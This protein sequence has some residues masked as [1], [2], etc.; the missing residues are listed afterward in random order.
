MGRNA[1]GALPQLRL[2]KRSGT[3][4]VRVGHQEYWL[5]RWGDPETHRKYAAFVVDYLQRPE[6]AP[7]GGTLS[8]PEVISSADCE[9]RSD[10]EAQPGHI[11]ADATT[12]PDGLT[13]AELCARYLDYAERHYTLPSG[14]KSTTFGNVKMGIRALAPFDRVPAEQ[15]GPVL[16]TKLMYGMVDQPSRRKAKDGKPLPNTLSSINATIKQVRRIF[17][18]A[19]SMEMIPAT[20]WHALNSVELL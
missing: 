17:R 2:H 20:V 1:R 14:Q 7:G 15:F 12:V 18:W 5:G 8:T 6:Q 11:L 13:V 10:A 16:L 4:R 9:E 3:A 19:V